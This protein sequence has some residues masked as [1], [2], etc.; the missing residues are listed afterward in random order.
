MLEFDLWLL[1]DSPEQVPDGRMSAFVQIG[2]EEPV[3]LLDW[4]FSGV[5]IN[6]N[7]A[8]PTARFRLPEV[9]GAREMKII[10][11]CGEYSAEY[12]LRYSCPVS[13]RPKEKMLNI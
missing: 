11:S 4:D 1:N 10:L 12:P 3:H 5:A 6:T 2:G 13:N 7:L 8:G 9:P